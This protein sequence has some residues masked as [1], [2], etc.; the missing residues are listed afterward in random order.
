MR[1]KTPTL[2]DFLLFVFPRI[3][4]ST[5]TNNTKNLLNTRYIMKTHPHSSPFEIA[6]ELKGRAFRVSGETVIFSNYKD[7]RLYKQ[8]L[9]SKDSSST[10]LTPYYGGP[11]IS[12]A[13][14]VFDSG[15][16]R[17]I[18]VQEDRRKSTNSTTTIVIVCLGSDNIQEPEVLVGGNDFYAFSHLD[19]KGERMTWIEW[20]HPNMLWDKAELWGLIFIFH[21]LIG[22]IFSTLLYKEIYK[23]ICVAGS[24][25]TVV[26]SPIKPKWS[27]D[28]E[29]FFIT[30]KESGFWNL[31]KWVE[32]EN[33][34]VPVYSLDAEFFGPLWVFG[35]NSYEII[36]QSQG[37]KCLIA[38]TY[39]QKGR[40]YLGILDD[41]QHT[42]SLLD[43]PFTDINNIYCLYMEG[44]SASQ[45]SSIAKVTLDDHKSKVVD[46]KIIWSSSPDCSS[47]LD[48]SSFGKFPECL[49]LLDIP[50]NATKCCSIENIICSSSSLSY[51]NLAAPAC[52][53]SRLSF[54]IAQKIKYKSC[55]QSINKVW[56]LYFDK[57]VV[58]ITVVRF[59]DSFHCLRILEKIKEWCIPVKMF[60][61]VIGHNCD[62]S[63]LG[64]TLNWTNPHTV[65]D[66]INDSCL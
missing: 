42:M 56:V 8:L 22:L 11:V 63:L 9:N 65:G 18:T 47:F 5:S 44:A 24:D 57:I 48:M 59:I 41:V 7:Q 61:L 27:S 29:L 49:L 3:S 19:P 39:K 1:Q 21:S 28:R 32:S 37:G 58:L 20:S 52:C 50:F 13:D 2:F 31:H 60:V 6:L 53:K 46:F 45:P 40:S 43:V 15:F 64:Y 33:K 25:P 12:Y 62:T 55:S 51:S 34:V 14:G 4:S 16:N 10:P 17:F 30:D 23:R 26:E 35:T 66:G 38:F 36:H 54:L